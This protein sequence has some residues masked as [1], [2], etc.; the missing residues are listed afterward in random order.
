MDGSVQSAREDRDEREK[1]L[2]RFLELAGAAYIAATTPERR[3][4]AML[5]YAQA[6]KDLDDF[7]NEEHPKEEYS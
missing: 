1:R 7:L 4:E 3:V 2:R 6:R 5:I